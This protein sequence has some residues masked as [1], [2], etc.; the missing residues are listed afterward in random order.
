MPIQL[1]DVLE[2]FEC[3]PESN[4]DDDHNNLN[5]MSADNDSCDEDSDEYFKVNDN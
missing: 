2:N 4:N 5:G 1:V 3:E